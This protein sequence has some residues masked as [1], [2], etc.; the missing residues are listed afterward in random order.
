MYVNR[1][2]NHNHLRT[3]VPPKNMTQF[4][5]HPAPL[6]RKD[7]PAVAAWLALCL[8]LV[9]CM[10]LVGGYTRLSGS[11][12]S[13]TQWKPI[14][15][16]IPPQGENEWQEEFEAYRQSPQYEKINKG[17]TLEEFKTIFWP[18]FWHRVLG[19]MVGVVFLVPLL[20]FAW[21]KSFS[22]R[23][24]LRLAAIF[25]L[26]GLQGLVGWIMVKSGLVD[27]PFVSHIK[28]AMHLSIAF[29]VFGLIGWAM[30]DVVAG[31][32]L[33]MANCKRR[34][35]TYMGWFLLLC[36]QIILGAMVAGTHAGLVFNTYPT[37]NGDWLPAGLLESPWLDNVTL[38]QFLH[39]K[40]ALL[41]VFGF[42]FWWYFNRKYVREKALGKVCSWVALLIACQFA[43]GVLTLL[44]QVP[45]KLALSHQMMAL[46]LFAGA[47]M[48][49]HRLFHIRQ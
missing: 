35:A 42:I 31:S 13:I 38:I 32:K 27:H 14:H 37:M 23:F 4:P 47:V 36:L 22:A 24:G 48:L 12:L 6:V 43:L 46:A 34:P 25:A 41:V 28:L 16:V 1:R 8:L 18:E 19:R 39:R 15:G 10:V 11:G 7:R 2:A 49:L 20:V 40:T 3:L 44:G 9:A 26:G 45:L 17:M 30:L 29:A 5:P 21:R 33:P